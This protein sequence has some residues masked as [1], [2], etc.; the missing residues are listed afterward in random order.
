MIPIENWARIRGHVEAVED[1]DVTDHVAV[2]LVLEAV[3]SVDGFPNRLHREPGDDLTVLVRRTAV[4]AV[5]P[6]AV[7][8]ARV[9]RTSL[10]RVYAHPEDV[11][12]EPP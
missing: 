5:D 8:D 12:V 3:E 7:L 10:D 6:G 1:A 2:H 9:R 4:D 11:E